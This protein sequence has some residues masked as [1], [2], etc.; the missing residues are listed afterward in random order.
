MRWLSLLVL[1]C[2]GCGLFK[3]VK[4]QTV[5]DQESFK[6][7]ERVSL[8]V[9]NDVQTD[10][11]V[12]EWQLDSAGH[13]SIVQIWPKGRFTFSADAGFEGEADKVM[14]SSDSWQAKVKLS[15]KDSTVKSS[16]ELKFNG[17]RKEAVKAEKKNTVKTETPAFWLLMGLTVLAIAGVLI[18][19]ISARIKI[20]R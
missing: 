10:Q 19:I 15:L 2:F 7:D 1:L 11:H 12:V 17:S 20:L 6:V 16:D 3:N 5:S 14:V 9:S 4:T 18:L 13:H 8:A